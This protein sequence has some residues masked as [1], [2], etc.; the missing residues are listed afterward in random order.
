MS[1]VNTR[2]VL[3][4][5]IP[6]ATTHSLQPH[7]QQPTSRGVLRLDRTH[8]STQCA[9]GGGVMIARIS[10]LRPQEV[11]VEHSPQFEVKTI[12][13][14]H[15]VIEETYI[16]ALYRRPQLVSTYLLSF[17]ANYLECIP[18]ETV[19]T[20]ILGD[21]N[22]NL[23]SPDHSTGIIQLLEVRGRWSPNQLQ[24][25]ALCWII[26]MS[27]SQSLSQQWM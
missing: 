5:N 18:H 16:I 3:H 2:D 7:S 25:R 1:A 8:E 19:P 21:F 11:F 12:S 10:N 14:C 4:R 6:Q 27:T 22:N 23:L 24:T 9:S 13:I 26:S 15:E 20:V 17:L